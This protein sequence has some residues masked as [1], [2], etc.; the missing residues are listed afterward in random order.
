MTRILIATTLPGS[1]SIFYNPFARAFKAQGWGV[2]GMCREASLCSECAAQ[3]DHLW[4][5]NWRRNP[6]YPGNLLQAPRVVRNIVEREGYDVI[7][8]STP[9]AS[10]VTRLALRNLKSAKTPQILYINHGFHFHKYNSLINNWI[11]IFLERLAGRWTDYL[12]VINRDDAEAALRLKLVPP[13]RL[14]HTLGIGVDIEKFSPEGVPGCDVERFRNSLHLVP[15]N[16][17]YSLVAEFIPRKRHRDALI[18][19]SRLDVPLAHLAL[20]GEGPLLEDM[21]KL[22]F[23]LGIGERVHFLGFRRDVPVII[24]ASVALLSVSEQEGLPGT[25]MQSLS[26]GIPVIGSDIRGTRD[27]L[28]GECGIIYPLGDLGRLTE[29]MSWM[30]SHPAK[31]AGM[32]SRGRAKMLAGYTVS[33]IVGT[34]ISFIKKIA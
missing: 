23:D 24:R 6:L 28:E 7:I 16:P 2:D 20:A 15:D 27:L 25:V 18:A 30:V 21:R 5:V 11:F 26:L 22:S 17:L 1:L 19:F 14:I 13:E 33:D 4:D 34:Y 32:G 10:F 12:A 29:A 8:V 3:F 9:V 31:A